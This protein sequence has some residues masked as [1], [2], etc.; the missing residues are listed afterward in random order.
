MKDRPVTAKFGGATG[1]YN[2]HHVAYP[3]Y[4]W[5]LFGTK[6]V[7]EKLALE[8]VKNIRLQISN[9]DNLSAIFDAMKRINTVG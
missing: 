4:D 2:A 7:A 5:K 3:E 9:Y 6:F 1:N 8:R